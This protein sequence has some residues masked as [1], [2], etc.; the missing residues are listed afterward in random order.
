MEKKTIHIMDRFAKDLRTRLLLFVDK[1]P[2]LL[3]LK[4][5]LRRRNLIILECPEA[6]KA[7]SAVPRFEFDLILIDLLLPG[8]FSGYDLCRRLKEN[9]LTRAVP[10]FLFCDHP[11]PFEVTRSYTFELKAQRLIIPPFDPETIDRQICRLLWPKR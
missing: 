9:D 2:A 5:R 8:D 11:L 6:E 3:P 1:A 4:R 7:L 10:I